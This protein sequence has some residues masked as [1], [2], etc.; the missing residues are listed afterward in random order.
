MLHSGSLAA[1]LSASAQEEV[2]IGS[3]TRTRQTDFKICIVY[4]FLDFYL[5]FSPAKIMKMRI[6]FNLSK[7][8]SPHPD[9]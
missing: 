5:G 1:W 6:I 4:S 2:K 8:N 7:A 9:A 3:A